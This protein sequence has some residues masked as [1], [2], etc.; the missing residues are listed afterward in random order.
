MQLQWGKYPTEVHANSYL[1]AL[2]ALKT[3]K[4]KCLGK[5]REMGWLESICVFRVAWISTS[6]PW[7]LRSHVL[8]VHYEEYFHHYESMLDYY[9]FRTKW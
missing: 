1:D 6:L 9:Q 7:S 3:V 5:T 4:T 2:R 8:S